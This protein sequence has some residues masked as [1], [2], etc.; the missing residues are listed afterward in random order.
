MAQMM[1]RL[2][3]LIVLM[4]LAHLSVEL[5]NNFMPIVYPL[6]ISSMD[7]TYTQ[8]GIVAL[9]AATG[10]SLVQPVFGFWSD[11]WGAPRMTI[12]SIAWLGLLMGL[13]GLA[14]NYPILVL[15]VGLGALGS[16]A[17]HPAGATL[18][19]LHG[20]QRRGAA[21]SVFSVSGTV[22]TAMSPLL[23][24]VGIGWLGLSGTLVVLPV[25][26]LVS[27]FLFQQLGRERPVNDHVTAPPPQAQ[28]YATPLP[29]DAGR[30]VGLGLI[31]LAAMCRS[32]FHLSLVTYLP[33]WLQSQGHSLETSGQILSLLLVAISAG[34]LIGGPLS[35][36]IG[37]WQVFALSLGLLP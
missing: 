13:V 22:G 32:W 14:W 18:A 21:M 4:A 17:F 11:R 29:L 1:T 25:A 7:L 31:I 37:R 23:V 12:V 33:E 27:L 2:P 30:L 16:A 26:L 15:L 28:P 35:D 34:S 3:R 8:V 6:F 20:G 19:S 5:C 9:V 10:A 24:A 36:A